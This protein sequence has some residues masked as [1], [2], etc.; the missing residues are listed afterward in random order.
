LDEVTTWGVWA[1]EI[2]HQLQA[3]GPPHPSNYNSNFEQMDAEYPAQSGVFEKQPNTAF[4]GWLPTEKYF[5]VK[6]PKG[7]SAGLLA[8]EVPPETE[9]G[10]YQAIKAFLTFGGS[11]I[12]YLISL[13]QRALGDDLNTA[14]IPHGIPDEGVLIERVVEGGDPDNP[15][16]DKICDKDGKN[17][18]NKNCKRRWVRVKGN[19]DDNHRNTLWRQGD[20]YSNPTDGIF[21]A[22]RQLTAPGF[23]VDVRYSDTAGQPDVGLNSWLEPQ[24]THTRPR[25]SGSTVRST[26]TTP[27]AIPYGPT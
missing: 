24:E 27:T 14:Q 17:C 12:Y 15:D 26:Y 20:T 10:V 5:V 9:P 3:K 8:E 16:C 11:Q 1:H 18:K 22:V 21:I 4:P 25:T 2:G 13:R 19:P 6:P 23:V 7:G